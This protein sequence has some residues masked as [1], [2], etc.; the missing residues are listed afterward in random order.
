MRSTAFPLRQDG[1][2]NTLSPREYG[3]CFGSA[4]P[5]GMNC[6]WA[7]GSVRTLE[8][9]IPW[10]ELNALGHRADGEVVQSE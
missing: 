8:Y 6:V 7:D 1:D 2:D 5:V 4:H 9:D 10:R 3:F